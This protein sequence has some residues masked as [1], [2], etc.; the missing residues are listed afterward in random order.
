MSESVE[1]MAEQM[2]MEVPT[3]YGICFALNITKGAE[4]NEHTN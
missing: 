4:K 1:W 3:S 2:C